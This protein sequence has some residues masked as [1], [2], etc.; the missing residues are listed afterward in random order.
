MQV[1]IFI[2]SIKMSQEIAPVVEI[3]K[4]VRCSKN[5]Y[6]LQYILRKWKISESDKYTM[7]KRE[8]EDADVSISLVQLD[9]SV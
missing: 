4:I 7:Q 6:L 5:E 8:I 3:P 1:G 9:D 2:L